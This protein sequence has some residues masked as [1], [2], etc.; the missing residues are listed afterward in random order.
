MMFTH[1][2]EMTALNL[3]VPRAPVHSRFAPSTRLYPQATAQNS[4][5]TPASEPA[6]PSP[7]PDHP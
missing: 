3:Q 7:A 5:A 2:Q 4:G 1:V 6:K